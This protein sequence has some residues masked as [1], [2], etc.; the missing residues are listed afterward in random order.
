MASSGHT[1]RMWPE[2]LSRRALSALISA[3]MLSKWGCDALHE[4]LPG[5]GGRHIAGGAGE[6]TDAEPLLQRP[7]RMTE[8][9]SGDAQAWR[10]LA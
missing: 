7:D 8:G 10:P 6:E 4:A 3:A 2:G 9:R 5:R 1:M